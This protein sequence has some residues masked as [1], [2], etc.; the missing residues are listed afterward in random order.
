MT[1]LRV[2]ALTAL[3]L[4]I[5]GCGGLPLAATELPENLVDSLECWG[6]E[7]VPALAP[8]DVL[9]GQEVASRLRAERFPPFIPVGARMAAPAY[10]VL[11]SRP[12]GTCGEGAGVVGAGEERGVWLVVWP[13]VSGANGGQAWAIVDARTGAFLVGDGP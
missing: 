5:L 4:A 6:D 11:S 3:G 2:L 12:P 13:E 1:A 8:P 9:T 10:G 7:F